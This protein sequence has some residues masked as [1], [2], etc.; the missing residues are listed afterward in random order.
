MKNIK[1]YQKIIAILV[2]LL[3]LA[4]LFSEPIK[5]QLIITYSPDVS[6]KTSTKKDVSFD[7]NRVDRLS[8]YDV[9]KARF[10]SKNIQLL[11]KIYIPSIKLDLPIGKGVSNN[12]LSLGV[13]TMN[14]DQRMGFGNYALAGHNM[15][16]GKTLFSPLYSKGKVGMYVYLTDMDKIFKYK[17]NR[18]MY[19]SPYQT[20]II[21]S[22]KKPILTLITCNDDGSKRL[23]AQ[24]LLISVKKK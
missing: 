5:K 8:L 12:V 13:G 23:V 11:G 21:Q 18:L 20:N 10:E 24:G 2:L 1:L 6:K 3:G 9:I 17:I 22:S 14:P 16:D 7:M 19:I 15:D 4:L